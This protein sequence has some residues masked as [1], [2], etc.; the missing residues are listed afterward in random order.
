MTFPFC[1]WHMDTC[2]CMS[3]HVEAR[4]Q[5]QHL[6][7]SLFTFQFLTQA[8]SLTCSLAFWLGYLAS[9]P[10][11]V[12]QVDLGSQTKAL[13]FEQQALFSLNHL[14]SQIDGF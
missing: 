5:H 8:L 4:S 14:P 9:K 13:L 2:E 3:A 10:R 6:T 11:E 7:Q 1:V 12:L